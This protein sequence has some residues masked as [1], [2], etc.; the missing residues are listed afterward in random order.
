MKNFS[1]NLSIIS[2][3]F[4]LVISCKSS[5]EENKPKPQEPE[6]PS[7]KIEKKEE[8]FL[9]DNGA[10]DISKATYDEKGD[11]TMNIKT[12]YT[13]IS[14]IDLQP[15]IVDVMDISTNKTKIMFLLAQHGK[16]DRSSLRKQG[17]NTKIIPRKG[18]IKDVIKN[19]DPKLSH[20]KGEKVY[21]IVLHDEDYKNAGTS[22]SDRQKIIECLQYAAENDFEISQDC[23]SVIFQNPIIGFKE[24]LR[25]RTFGNGG[26]IPPSK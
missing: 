24:K 12:P 22:S 18:N 23:I 17:I 15:R 11:Y 19:F 2:L 4:L 6:N 25:P 26:V 1:I 13:T 16:S 3:L 10:F 20:S 8:V 9:S 14:G 21:A 7:E 5:T